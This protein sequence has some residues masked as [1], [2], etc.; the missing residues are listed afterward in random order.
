MKEIRE[1]SSRKDVHP[2][3]GKANV[4]LTTIE[5]ESLVANTKGKKKEIVSSSKRKFN[6]R[7]HLSFFFFFFLSLSLSSQKQFDIETSGV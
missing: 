4:C 6:F 3:K 1:Q 7:L 5:N 2:G